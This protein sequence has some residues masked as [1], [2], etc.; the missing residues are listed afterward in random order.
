MAR[1]YVAA[2]A[3]AMTVG[4]AARG[5]G[6]PAV[7]PGSKP[8]CTARGALMAPCC[9]RRFAR[10]MGPPGVLGCGEPHHASAS[11]AA[12]IRVTYELE[13]SDA[14][15]TL[16]L[17]ASVG[18]ANGPEHVRGRVVAR[19]DGHALLEFPESNWGGDVTLLV[20]A[21]LAG[22][23]ADLADLTRCRVVAAEWPSGLFR[24]PA[25]DAPDAVLVGAIVKPSLG[26][27][28]P[29]VADTVAALGRG[30]ADLVK[31]DE[32]L[33]DPEWC[34]L[35]DRVRAVAA[36][37]ETTYA[38]NVT[39]PAD[40]LLQRAELAVR[41]GAGALLVNVFAQGLDALRVLREAELGVPILAHRAGGA[42]WTRNTTHGAAPSV[43]AQLLR[44]L[45]AD[46]VFC[47]SFTGRV[48][49]PEADVRLQVEACHVEL[50]VSRSVAVLGGGVGPA[51]AAE[52]I[53]R[54]NVSDGVMVL[55]GSEAYRHSGG[56]E[57]AV[58]ATVDAVR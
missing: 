21:L 57:E 49:D 19:G 25:F 7:A 41:L 44:L 13:P 11:V 8:L 20:S 2:A 9:R 55:L 37:T 39:G 16:A 40:M 50:G 17:V 58:R 23:W 4:T 29:E 45:G 54:L 5:R 43:V 38:A 32:L 6:S 15:E 22:E 46:Y 1:G 34:P 10:G 42:L 24:G 27:T 51:N 14:A 12:V 31:D 26:L 18:H 36:A 3:T 53:E 28:P 33:G 52:Q 47:G 48:F 56:I 35:A 30:G